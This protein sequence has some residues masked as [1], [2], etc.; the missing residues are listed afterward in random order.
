MNPSLPARIVI[1]FIA[2]SVFFGCTE[3]KKA[4][5]HQEYFPISPQEYRALTNY[6]LADAAFIAQ[7]EQ[8]TEAG[9]TNARKIKLL[10]NTSYEERTSVGLSKNEVDA[11]LLYYRSSTE[12]LNRFRAIDS[13][14]QNA[15]V[16]RPADIDSVIQD[17]RKHLEE[18]TQP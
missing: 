6:F 5:R 3:N 2:I 11:L 18:T 7:L 15:I 17:A 16:D 1:I 14:L 4:N 12:A 8:R 9:D 13:T 10:L